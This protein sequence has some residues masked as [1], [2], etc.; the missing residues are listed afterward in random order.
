MNKFINILVNFTLITACQV[1][2]SFVS[3]PVQSCW[4]P[5]LL[6][7][8]ERLPVLVVASVPHPLLAGWDL[9]ATPWKDRGDTPVMQRRHHTGVGKTE[10]LP[11]GCQ[12]VGP[13]SSRAP[14]G[15][16]MD[17][18]I[19]TPQSIDELMEKFSQASAPLPPVVKV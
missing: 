4:W 3:V 11:G 13:T 17:K 18:D 10:V 1:C 19:A 8:Y 15:E 16:G 6:E 14:P 9:T 7:Q 5:S 12:R 2:D